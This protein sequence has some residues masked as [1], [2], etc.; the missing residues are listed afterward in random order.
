MEWTVL[1]SFALHLTKSR[2]QIMTYTRTARISRG[3]LCLGRSKINRTVNLK[4]RRKW[5]YAV[6]FQRASKI[7][8]FT[9]L[10]LTMY[11]MYLLELDFRHSRKVIPR[12]ETE[13]NS[14]QD[15]W[16]SFSRPHVG[17][18]SPKLLC[19]SMG[20]AIYGGKAQKLRLLLIGQIIADVRNMRMF[21]LLRHLETRPNRIIHFG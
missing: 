13:Q 21:T 20:R 11:L 1:I 8:T 15:F 7:W 5:Y 14:R 3:W 12:Q 17:D 10:P 19:T 9:Y 16:S 18:P 6:R 2:K 4:E